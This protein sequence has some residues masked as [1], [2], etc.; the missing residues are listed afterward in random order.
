MGA[1]EGSVFLT[2]DRTEEEGI[3]IKK[4]DVDVRNLT[5]NLILTSEIFGFHNI[6]AKSNVDQE[7]VHTED[8]MAEKKFRDELKKRLIRFA[9]EE[10]DYPEGLFKK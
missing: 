8:T 4:L 10:G 1:P 3:T 5:P 6:I 7:K 9:E 2:V